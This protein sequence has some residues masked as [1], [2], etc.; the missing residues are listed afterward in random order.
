MKVITLWAIMLAICTASIA[1]R[2]DYSELLPLL[3]LSPAL[4]ALMWVLSL[5][6]GPRKRKRQ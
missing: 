5:V 6:V 3:A 2:Q 4:L 1:I